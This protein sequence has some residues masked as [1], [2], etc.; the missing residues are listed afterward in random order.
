M[1]QKYQQMNIKTRLIILF[2]IFFCFVLNGWSI[3]R[4]Q[5][6]IQAIAKRHFENKG[7][8][9]LTRSA[10]V[11]FESVI[12]SG[13]LLPQT[14]NVG[15]DDVF[16]VFN[17]TGAGFVIVSADDRLKPVL[18]YSDTGS[19][20]IDGLPENIKS[21]LQFYADE[22]ASVLNDNPT[23]E[24]QASISIPSS[25]SSLPATVAPLLGK[26]AWNQDAP[27]NNLCPVYDA[28][29]T[30]TGCLATAMAQIMLYH[31]Y[32]NVGLGTVG[33]TTKTLK[34]PLTADLSTVSFKWD[35]LLDYYN[36]NDNSNSAKYAAELSYY[37]GLTLDMDYNT[38]KEGGSWAYNN[39]LP[40]AIINHFGYDENMQFLSRNYFSSSEWID[41]IKKELS[42]SRPIFYSGQSIDGGHAFVLDG[43]DN[44]DR[45]HVNWGWGG[46]NN[47]YFETTSLNPQ[48]H[49]IGGGVGGFN[50][51]Q[52]MAIGIQKPN[53]TS[54]YK[55]QFV[56][57]GSLMI[58]E[59]IIPRNG[60]FS[61]N[62]EAFYNYGTNFIKGQLGF[63]LYQN[64]EIKERLLVYNLGAADILSGW[65]GPD[66]P[67]ALTIKG[68]TPSG[69]YQLHMV[70]KESRDA[71]WTRVR[72]EMGKLGYYNVSITDT[73]ISFTEPNAQPD[74]TVTSFE[75]LHQLYQGLNGEYKIKIRNDGGEFYP[76][77]GVLLQSDKKSVRYTQLASIKTIIKSGEEIELHLSELVEAEPGEYNVVIAYSSGEDSWQPISMS[78]PKTLTVYPEPSGI[79]QLALTKEP[80][81]PS[82]V[83]KPGDPVVISLS[84]KNTGI[85]FSDNL[86]FGFFTEEDENSIAVTYE[87]IFIDAGKTKEFTF[88]TYPGITK[89]GSYFILPIYYSSED[90]YNFLIYKKGASSFMFS[91]DNTDVSN[92]A[93]EKPFSLYPTSTYDILN[94]Q[95][96][97]EITK[98]N[99]FS[100]SGIRMKQINEKIPAGSTHSISVSDL[101]K[102]IYFIQIQVGNKMYGTK[103][104][105]K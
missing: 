87:N 24:K 40:Y 75:S 85:V 36:Y 12:P 17:T 50:T 44:N 48:T 30:V 47:G 98:V 73:E 7:V 64:G 31:K 88:T 21:W 39:K 68:S 95:A 45:V 10:G 66:T 89:G 52:I 41:M 8:S 14:R 69:N 102:G 20:V 9:G 63:A 33:Y 79:I 43:Y 60:S 76:T 72:A 35:Q 86:Y 15:V 22:M 1:L 93:V 71:D 11:T 103:F 51:D 49:G 74:L 46:S 104:I 56:L 80:V 61:L 28:K 101:S 90:D 91:V 16:Y 34:I 25:K 99:I 67:I 18:G 27:Y 4:T 13:M 92:E 54:K 57:G 58:N 100:M 5:Q 32:P 84:I 59:S 2:T 23:D 94:I 83:I 65:K 96:T 3:P 53:E 62:F 81:L 77:I 105:K 78:E 37:C 97:E 6:E 29:K 55:S 42:E 82:K 38:A 26:I 70:V 19:F